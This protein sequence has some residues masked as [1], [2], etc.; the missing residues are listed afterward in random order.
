VFSPDE[1]VL[2]LNPAKSTAFDW[3]EPPTTRL[4]DRRKDFQ[5]ADNWVRSRF[6]FW[7]RHL[8]IQDEMVA[9]VEFLFPI[10]RGIK[11]PV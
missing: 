10:P 5:L 6:E 8:K 3:L 9:H 11:I 4:D 1:T 2:G 7:F